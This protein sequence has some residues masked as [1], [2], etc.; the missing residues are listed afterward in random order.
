MNIK[1]RINLL[2]KLGD[3]LLL[4]DEALQLTKQ[5]AQMQNGWFTQEFIDAAI[6]NIVDNFLQKDLLEAWVNQYEINDDIQPKKVGIIMAGNIPLVGFHDFLCVFISGHK[7]VIKPSSKDEVLIKHVAQKII[8]WNKEAEAVISFA[9]NLK[10]C[11]AYIATGSNNSGRYFEYYFGKYPNI[12]RRNKTSVAILKGD[13]SENELKLLT[14]DIQ[15]YFGMGCRN[16]THV[17]V[18]ANYDFVPLLEALKKYDYFKDFHKYKNNYDY[19]LALL[20][21]NHKFYMTNDSILLTENESVFAP[22]S[23]LN[24]SFYDDEKNIE[25]RL[26]ANENIQCIIGRNFISFGKSQSPSLT[27]Y[28]DGIDTMQFLKQL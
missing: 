6:K 25:E 19:Q 14:N 11:D 24:Y 18:P 3:Y 20:I 1:N 27:D 21:L 10:N 23:Q 9:E 2:V 22:V 8:E 28:A 15:Q 5:K 26:A 17:F 4:N 12:I 16:V 13:E 7:A